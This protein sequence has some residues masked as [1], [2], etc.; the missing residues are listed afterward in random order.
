MIILRLKVKTH[1]G[2]NR[3]REW[4]EEWY[5]LEERDQVACCT[6]PAMMIASINDMPAL[7]GSFPKSTRWIAKN[8]DP[9]YEIIGQSD[10]SDV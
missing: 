2:K 9:D 1:K 6:G 5:V 10:S 4:G 8:N 7:K 3:C